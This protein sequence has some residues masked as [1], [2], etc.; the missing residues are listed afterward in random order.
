MKRTQAPDTGWFFDVR[1]DFELAASNPGC[2][3]TLGLGDDAS[4]EITHRTASPLGV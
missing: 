2:S 4:P 1:D 3:W